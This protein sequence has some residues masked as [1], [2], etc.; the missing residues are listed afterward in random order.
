M[1]LYD[2]EGNQIPLNKLSAEIL[3]RESTYEIVASEQE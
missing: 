3:P 2:K 1:Y